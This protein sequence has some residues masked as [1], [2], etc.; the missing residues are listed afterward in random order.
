MSQEKE[1]SPTIMPWNIRL[2]IFLKSTKTN[3]LNIFHKK[4]F[5][6]E[7]SIKPLKDKSSTNLKFNNRVIIFIILIV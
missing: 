6:K 2:S 5:K 4:E 7:S 3:M 1:K